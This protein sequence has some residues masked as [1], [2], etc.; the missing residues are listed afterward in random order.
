MTQK[1]KFGAKIISAALSLAM[2]A[3]SFVTGSIPAM[4]S[5]VNAASTTASST[6]TPHGIMRQFTSYLQTVSITVTHLMTIATA[7]VLTRRVM[8]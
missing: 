3:T 4:N 8:K 6:E 5:E 7:E 2:V 1:S